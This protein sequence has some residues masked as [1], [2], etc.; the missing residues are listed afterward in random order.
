MRKRFGQFRIPQ[1]SSPTPTTTSTL[2]TGPIAVFRSSSM[3]R[4]RWATGSQRSLARR[5]PSAS[6]RVRTRCFISARPLIP[7]AYSRA[8]GSFGERYVCGG[9]GEAACAETGPAFA[10]NKGGF[11]IGLRSLAHQ[12]R[13]I[14]NPP[15]V[16]NLPYISQ[17]SR[18]RFCASVASGRISSCHLFGSSPSV[19]EILISRSRRATKIETLSP[20]L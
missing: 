18:L 16:T 1:T 7:A 17:L 10:V 8:G 4:Y 6:L 13:R 12:S 15:Q 9:N 3:A 5:T 11:V 19:R 14:A 2:P 20:G